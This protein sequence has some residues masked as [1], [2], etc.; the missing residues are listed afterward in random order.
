MTSEPLPAECTEAQRRLAQGDASQEVLEHVAG[1]QDC[2]A[3]AASLVELEA[4]LLRL[5]QPEPPAG[6]ADRAVARFRAELAIAALPGAASLAEPLKPAMPP[7][8]PL[9][10]SSAGDATPSQAPPGWPPHTG[11]ARRRWWRHPASLAAGF[12]AVIALVVALVAVPGPA[13][14]PLTEA[15][16]LHE[17]AVDTGN[18]KSARFDLAGDIGLSVR[19]QTLTAVLSGAGSSEFPDR[20]ELTEVA[21]LHGRPLLQQDIVSVGNRVWTR[22]AGGPWTAVPVPPDHASRIDQALADPAYALEDLSRVGSGYRSLGTTTVSGA[23]VR[24]IRLTI[25]GDSFR[26]FG[27]LQKK[28]SSRWTVVVGVSQSSLILR[29]LTITGR[30]V[31][32]VLGTEAPFTYYLQLN[33]RDF[34]APVSIQ[35]PLPRCAHCRPGSTGRS[36]TT[37]PARGARTSPRATPSPSTG[38]TSGAPPSSSPTPRPSSSAP[39]P[40]PTPTGSTH[41][42]PTPTSSCTP[43]PGSATTLPVPDRPCRVPSSSTA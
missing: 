4:R 16:I 18:E 27:N 22:T 26:P 3:F 39:S 40:S 32:S 12:A 13:S 36:P 33:L 37:T 5:P 42:S 20:G 14:T 19:G 2:S 38:P 29:R 28:A 11:Q 41:P 35:A 6:A 9:P 10:S 24:Q 8:T 25:P 1:C 21:T 30:G 15:A 34:G 7:V 17:A 23:R 43:S 31:V